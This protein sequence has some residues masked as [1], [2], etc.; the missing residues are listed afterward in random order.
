MTAT[1]STRSTQDLNPGPDPSD[2]TRHFDVVVVGAGLAGLT[3]ALVAARAGASVGLVEA[4]EEAGGRARSDTH[5]GYIVNQGPHALYRAGAAWSVLR[6]L[7]VVPAGRLPRQGGVALWSSGER[8]SL[9]RAFKLGGFDALRAVKRVMRPGRRR[10]S[11]AQGATMSQWLDRNVSVRGRST[12]EAVIRTSCYM[13]ELDQVDASAVLDQVA[14]SARGVVYLHGGWESLVRQ[15]EAQ[16]ESAGVVTINGR[17]ESIERRGSF[18]MLSTRS[19]ESI[20]A[21]SV[22]LAVGG[23]GHVDRLLGGRSEVVRSW[24]EAA[25]PI[26]AACLDVAVAPSP[27]RHPVATY[28]LGEPVYVVDH[29]ATAKVAPAGGSVYHALF[30]EPDARPEA[31][32]RAVL[33]A[34]LDRQRPDWRVHAVQVTY[35]K[36]IV[37]AHD[38]PRPSLNGSD[39]GRVEI[40][41]QP[42]VFVVG[43]WIHSFGLLAD[44]A[45]GSGAEAGRLAALHAARGGD[46]TGREAEAAPDGSTPTRIAELVGE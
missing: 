45:V 4:R 10:R 44:A 6:E 23:P 8:I 19:G 1:P 38:R 41:D 15:L 24:A 42:G 7:G 34:I 36:R 5:D 33:E 46:P 2:D 28:G 30:Y 13:S 18:T 16:A 12:A 21:G 20:R 37:V 43:D 39:Q 22:V 29:G 26:T 32:H 31:D 35:R 25:H 14:R 3:S 27:G 17:I 11:H 40:G 9:T